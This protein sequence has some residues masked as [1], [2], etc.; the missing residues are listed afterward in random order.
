MTNIK[1]AALG[2][3]LCLLSNTANA[4]TW[5]CDLDAGTKYQRVVRYTVSNGEMTPSSTSGGRVTSLRVTLNDDR[6][7][8]AFARLT[9]DAPNPVEFMI[10]E[11]KSGSLLFIEN[12]RMTVSYGN[13]A[14]PSVEDNGKCVLLER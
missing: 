9:K 14:G 13:D 1:G 12:V 6:F 2:L 4:E 10:I 11:K 8:V 5:S 3:A 7:L